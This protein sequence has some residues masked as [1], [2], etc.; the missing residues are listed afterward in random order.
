MDILL[1]VL[2]VVI[3]C[4]LTAMF[5]DIRKQRD[6]VAAVKLAQDRRIIPDCFLEQEKLVK[7][8][9]KELDHRDALIYKDLDSG[10]K[11][12]QRHLE[13]IDKLETAVTKNTKQ[14]DRF[15]TIMEKNGFR[16]WDGR[17]RRKNRG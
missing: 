9:E 1:A 12:F 5:F 14:T 2:G 6:E 3:V 11:E 4:I 7:Q 15:V 13:K 17:E 10:I 8:I 16:E